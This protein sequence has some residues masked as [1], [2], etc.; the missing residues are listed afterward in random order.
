MRKA[1]RGWQLFGGTS[2]RG[3]RGSSGLRARTPGSPRPTAL[4][5]PSASFPVLFSAKSGAANY[6][7]TSGA[8]PS[9]SRAS[10]SCLSEADV[11]PLS[12]LP[13]GGQQ[14]ETRSRPLP[15]AELSERPRCTSP[16]ASRDSRRRSRI[17][18][19]SGHVPPHG[20]R[21][22]RHAANQPPP[23]ATEAPAFPSWEMRRRR[24][25]TPKKPETLRVDR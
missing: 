1:Q 9:R 20:V 6:S 17:T 12:E 14:G 23:S 16:V 25:K 8:R 22:R 3:R 15:S 13:D 10:A 19:H 5:P 21:R 11:K 24:F 4:P 7:D 2:A 18:P